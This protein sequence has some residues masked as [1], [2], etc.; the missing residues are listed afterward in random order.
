M[1]VVAPA[2]GRLTEPTSL[3]E[4]PSIFVMRLF[5]NADSMLAL[6]F[7]YAGMLVSAPGATRPF[8]A[9]ARQNC[10]GFPPVWGALLKHRF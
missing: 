7:A 6:I 2:P 10:E 1:L 4:E 5:I 8:L 9:G 3:A